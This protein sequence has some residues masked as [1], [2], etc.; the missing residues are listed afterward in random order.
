MKQ[1]QL[2][3]IVIAAV[4]AMAAGLWLGTFT[5]QSEQASLKPPIIQGMIL[6]VA[7]KLDNF[8]LTDA[9]GEPFSNAALQ[10][11]WSVLFAGYTH[12]PDVCPTTLNVVKNVVEILQE[13][14]LVVPQIVFVSV[15]PERDQLDTLQQYVT[16]FNQDFMGATGSQEELAKLSKQLGVF[17]QKVAGTSGDV[18]ASDYL[19][20]HSSSLMLINPRGELQAYLTAPHTP[21]KIVESILF[22][23]EFFEKTVN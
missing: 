2:F 18:N 10:N 9:S 14:T 15:D 21:M 1:N 12:C 23:Q 20:D 5:Q 17:Y 22:T 7:K 19:I 11:H 4:A 6:P 8:S 13:Q 16:Y 3:M